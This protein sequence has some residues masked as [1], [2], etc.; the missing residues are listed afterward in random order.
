MQQNENFQHHLPETPADGVRLGSYPQNR[1]A[2]ESTIARLNAFVRQND[3]P[4]FWTD[5]GFFVGG[6]PQNFMRHCDVTL[7][8]V[9]YC[10]VLFDRYR[11]CYVG[12]DISER[13]SA[14]GY[15]K[16][17]VHWF[18]WEPVGWRILRRQDGMALVMSK[19]ILDSRH[20]SADSLPTLPQWLNGE[21]FSEAFS[22]EE[23]RRI[24]FV[25]PNGPLS[26]QAVARP[27][28]RILLLSEQDLRDPDCALTANLSPATPSPKLRL[29]PSPYAQCMGVDM[30]GGF[31]RWW[32]RSSVAAGQCVDMQGKLDVINLDAT[33]CGVVPAMYIKI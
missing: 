28:R 7:D 11:P 1:V 30:H 15:K 31:G 3:R 14:N 27:D 4:D 10:G 32:L 23:R 12:A 20:Y 26:D 18:R 9:R 13:Q 8:G 33:C 2:D 24:C 17:L 25:G 16:G 6:Q 5:Y 19:L 22:D 21:F 29:R